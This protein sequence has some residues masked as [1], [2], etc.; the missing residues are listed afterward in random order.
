MDILPPFISPCFFK[1][2]IEYVEQVGEYRQFEPI[3]G[4][5]INWYNLIILT[6]IITKNFIIVSFLKKLTILSLI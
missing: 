2:S 3:N 5:I 4:E 6:I 1:A